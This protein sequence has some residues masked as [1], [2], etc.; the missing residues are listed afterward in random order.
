VDAGG[1][2]FPERILVSEFFE[3]WL[4]HL[5]TQD[6]LAPAIRR[7]YRGLT[8]TVLRARSRVP[9]FYW[10]RGPKLVRWRAPIG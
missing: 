1:D 5:E 10:L 3:R 6:K 9:V 2:A 4:E 7:G 8:R